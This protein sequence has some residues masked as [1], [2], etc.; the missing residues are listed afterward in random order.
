MRPE[1]GNLMMRILS[2]V[3]VESP[4]SFT[5]NNALLGRLCMILCAIYLRSPAGGLSG[6]LEQMLLFGESGN[7][8]SSSSSSGVRVCL[9]VLK[10]ITDEIDNADLSRPCKIELYDELAKE[11]AR[12][13]SLVNTVLSHACETISTSND[14][15]IVSEFTLRGKLSLEVLKNWINLSPSI[16]LGEFNEYGAHDLLAKLYQLISGSHGAVL[17]IHSANAIEALLEVC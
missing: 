9:E 4:P 1:L 3:A 12:V 17:A 11:R 2:M 7:S 16:A 13:V 5:V 8:S 10:T 6:M 15:S 14:N